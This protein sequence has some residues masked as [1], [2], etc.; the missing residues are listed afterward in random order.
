MK[1]AKPAL[2]GLTAALG[3]L[4]VNAAGTPA[5][6]PAGERPNLVFIFAD[7]F[8]RASLGFLGEDP[9]STP[10]LDALA[11]D[12][13]FLSQAAANYPL[14]S[15]FRGMLLT[16][17]YPITNGV[18]TNCNSMP[19][20]STCHLKKQTVCFTDV[21]ARGGYNVGYVGKWHLDS[22][23]VTNPK[24][25]VIWDTWCPP[26]RRHGVDFWYSYGTLNDHMHPHYWTNETPGDAPIVVNQWSP[27]Y[28]A[29]VI[30][31]YLKGANAKYR[32]PDK[33]FAVFWGINPP[34]SDF[35]SMPDSMLNQVA[36][37]K[38]EDVLNRPNVMFGPNPDI[39]VGDKLKPGILEQA[40]EYFRMVNGVDEQIGRVLAALR[41]MGLDKN[42]IV[43]F[44]A[45]HGDMMGSQGIMHK[46]IFFAESIDIPF[47][48]S[49]PGTIKPGVDD[50][51][52]SVP[53][54]MPTVLSLMGLE[55]GIPKSVEGRDYSGLFFGKTVVRPDCQLYIG[56][57]PSWLWG[58]KRGIKTL[59]YT[60]AVSKD[61]K[62]VKTYF[63]YDDL[64]DP[65]QMA[66]IWG[67]DPV[68]DAE[69]E[70]RLDTLLREMKD[71]WI[72]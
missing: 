60:F 12:G 28:E 3:S 47:I 59:E 36:G 37:L 51:L 72:E 45:D 52:I 69:M 33:P 23:P 56:T 63:L 38:P 57:D 53:D 55:S 20:R 61:K 48:L 11:R 7:Q 4:E 16:G 67:E 68:L 41:E 32:D 49:W 13:M 19:S 65:Y 46:N 70:S 42:T 22:P 26:D 18:T 27:E 14:S 54:Y 30:I 9:V 17:Q 43:V 24:D 15:P 29:D 66:N 5:E 39:K 8:R 2:L 1:Y 10:N 25:T 44:T 6:S 58:G 40:P 64:K 50:L 31:S 21:L 34:H 35:M 71:P 62:G